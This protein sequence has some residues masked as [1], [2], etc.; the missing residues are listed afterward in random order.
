MSRGGEGRAVGVHA[1]GAGFV[2]PRRLVEGRWDVA[3]VGEL[4]TVRLASSLVIL[5]TATATC[6]T[7]SIQ[8]Y[9]WLSCSTYKKYFSNGALTEPKYLRKTIHI[10]HKM[11]S[12]QLSL[13]PDTIRS[14][15]I[16]FAHCPLNLN[17]IASHRFVHRRLPRLVDWK[18]ARRRLP[19]LGE[20][21]RLFGRPPEGGLVPHLDGAC[22]SKKLTHCNR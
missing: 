11:A 12:K 21:A 1:R 13:L 19:R 18:V 10:Y 14:L 2:A 20:H 9:K 5:L 15:S 16:Q 3:E 8:N 7:F 6:S 22:L 4:L 17:R